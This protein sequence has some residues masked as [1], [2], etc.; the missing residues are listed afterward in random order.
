MNRRYKT[1]VQAALAAASLAVVLSLYPTARGEESKVTE[2]M[3]SAQQNS[4]V[5]KYCA[6]CH[7]D[8]LMYGG[9]SLEHFDAA[10]PE[11]SLAAM[12]GR[13]RCTGR[14]HAGGIRKSLIG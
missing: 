9:L 6:S 7:S 2:I 3:P 13:Q 5:R 14:D 1:T 4:V 12:L 11:P 8:A 10:H